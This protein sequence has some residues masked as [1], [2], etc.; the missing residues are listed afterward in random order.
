MVCV[1]CEAYRPWPIIG[2]FKAV[3]LTK[4]LRAQLFKSVNASLIGRSG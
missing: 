4:S 2:E 1:P 3:K